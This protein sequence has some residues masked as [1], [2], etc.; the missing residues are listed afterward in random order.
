[1]V[2]GVSIPPL[3]SSSQLPFFKV[4]A[5]LDV[6]LNAAGAGYLAPGYKIGGNTLINMGGAFMTDGPSLSGQ[7]GAIAGSVFG[8]GFG[9]YAPDLLAPYAGNASGFIG[10]IGGAF[11]FEYFNKKMKDSME[12]E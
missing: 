4:Q 5:G 3:A 1:M 10:D 9:K 11:T 2:T 6:A 12:K 7:G 8:G